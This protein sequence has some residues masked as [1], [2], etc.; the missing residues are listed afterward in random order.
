M[1]IHSL[2]HHLLLTTLSNTSNITQLIELWET[3][4]M[5]LDAETDPADDEPFFR[6]H[7]MQTEPLI[8]RTGPNAQHAASQQQQQSHPQAPLSQQQQQQR[9]QQQAGAP[10]PQATEDV[11]T[12][13]AAPGIGGAGLGISPDQGGTG[14]TAPGSSRAEP[15]GSRAGAGTGAAGG[16]ESDSS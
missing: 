16:N 4:L 7:V 10:P 14:E 9:Q 2:C 13:T 5:Q 6:P 1:L 15:D 12:N 11:E 8:P 3:Y